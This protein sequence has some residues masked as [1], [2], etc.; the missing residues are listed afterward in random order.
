MYDFKHFI[1]TYFSS[2]K[3]A[4]KT[5]G[6]PK[7]LKKHSS[8][9]VG[10]PRHATYF[11]RHWLKSCCSKI[12]SKYEKRGLSS[13]SHTEI[14]RKFETSLEEIFD[15]L[16]QHKSDI[17]KR[18]ML[19]LMPVARLLLSRGG[20]ML[21]YHRGGCHIRSALDWASGKARRVAD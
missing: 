1:F 6:W 8:I 15:S 19:L 21:R 13:P 4:H 9:S 5:F 20:C 16:E 11:P 7:L 2:H 14:V 12:N 18:R 10:P 3:K 17:A